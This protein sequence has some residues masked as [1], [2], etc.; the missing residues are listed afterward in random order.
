M[1]VMVYV[2]MMKKLPVRIHKGQ[3]FAV[4]TEVKT[5]LLSFTHWGL[6]FFEAKKKHVSGARSDLS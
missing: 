6:R 2:N 1:D 3:R 5:P 4:W